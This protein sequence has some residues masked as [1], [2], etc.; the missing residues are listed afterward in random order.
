MEP[1]ILPRTD[2]VQYNGATVTV[3]ELSTRSLLKVAD[4]LKQVAGHADLL[5]KI[6]SGDAAKV[7]EGVSELV[8]VLPG[9]VKE[10]IALGSDATPDMVM[11]ATP[12]QTIGLLK[13][14]LAVNNL[15]FGD[16]V[17]KAAGPTGGA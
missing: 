5:V 16:L 13:S 3:R 14:I 12:R 9:P 6:Q 7:L 8:Q 17:P 11:D 4:I 10:I 2:E 15:N 1:E